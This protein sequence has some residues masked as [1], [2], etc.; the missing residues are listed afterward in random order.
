MGQ[1][2]NVVEIPAAVLSG[3]NLDML[4]TNGYIEVHREREVTVE[5]HSLRNRV[6]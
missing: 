5:V 4:K 1:R 6:W 3:R 2:C